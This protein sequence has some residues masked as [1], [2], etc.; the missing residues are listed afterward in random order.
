MLFFGEI[1]KTISFI[2][3]PELVKQTF[4]WAKFFNAFGKSFI[5]RFGRLSDITDLFRYVIKYWLRH[6]LCA[7]NNVIAI[8]SHKSRAKQRFK[9]F[10]FL[11]CTVIN[12]NVFVKQIFF[13]SFFHRK[14]SPFVLV[15]I[16]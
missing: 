15:I 2:I 5:K 10:V 3:R 9:F 14:N 7:R 6:K 16:L 4:F 1:S 11:F 13:K 12:K 8:F